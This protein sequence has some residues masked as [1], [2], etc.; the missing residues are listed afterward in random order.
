MLANAI[1]IVPR[2]NSYTG[3]GSEVACVS[4]V[5]C[6]VFTLNINFKHSSKP[7][8]IF[9]NL[10][11]EEANKL[12]KLL[13]HPSLQPVTVLRFEDLGQALLSKQ[14]SQVLQAKPRHS[15]FHTLSSPGTNFTAIAPVSFERIGSLPPVLY[16]SLQRKFTSDNSALKSSSAHVQRDTLVPFAKLPSRMSSNKGPR[17]YTGLHADSVLASGYK[18]ADKCVH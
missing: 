1:G 6:T 14:R 13:L 11:H 12:G 18:Y 7:K 4:H 17:M 3:Y 16:E 10:F 8:L 2:K 5:A 9:L 15:P